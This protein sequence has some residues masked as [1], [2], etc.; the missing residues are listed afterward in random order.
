MFD[1]KMPPGVTVLQ[2]FSED[3]SIKKI[4]VEVIAQP[5]VQVCLDILQK[6][7]LTVFVCL[8]WV[9]ISRGTILC[10]SH[11]DF[12]KRTQRRDWA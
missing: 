3:S 4:S 11:G 8:L 1:T 2:P 5:V 9:G 10:S 12:V 6:K 7:K